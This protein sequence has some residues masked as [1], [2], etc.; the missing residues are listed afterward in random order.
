METKKKPYTTPELA[1][2]GDLK[3]LTLQAGATNRDMPT[4]SNNTAWPNVGS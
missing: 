1:V 3:K 4:G 2:H